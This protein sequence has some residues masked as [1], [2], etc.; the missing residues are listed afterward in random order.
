MSFDYN[1]LERK[2]A[3][4]KVYDAWQYVKSLQETLTYMAAS[5]EL[6]VK[7]Y[8]HRKKII[9]ETEKV[10]Y[11]TAME[12]G[13]A[14]FGENE[15]NKTNL[16]I[17]GY[18]IDDSIFLRKTALEFF[19][20]SRISMDVLF[21]I[22]NAALLG[23]ESYPVTD[24]QLLYDVSSK[25]KSKS[26][27]KTLLQLLNSNKQD[28][29]FKYLMAFDNHVK[30]IKTILI[31]I[32]NSFMIGEH[33][34]FVINGFYNNGVFYKDEVAI[35]KIKEINNYV[36]TTT[37]E[38][39]KEVLKQ[40]PN[41]IDNSQRVH[42]VKFKMQVDKA[43]NG[44][45]LSYIAF[46]IEVEN[47]L[48]DLPNE[49]KVLPLIIKPND[50]IYSFDLKHEKIFIRKIGSDENE[51]IG[52]AQLKNGIETNEFYRVFEVKTCDKSDYFKYIIDFQEKYKGI[53]L[54]VYAMEGQ[55][56]FVS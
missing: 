26:D 29:R 40:V 20:Y 47:G 48:G 37:E 45:G 34:E 2:L 17:A 19:H 27:F 3:E 30:H 14:S 6:L 35:D 5:Y 43:G 28:D 54:N 49:I 7:V 1:L 31:T 18:S 22:I 11:E 24:R 53:S 50:E 23:D 32:K 25:L 44:N 8:E 55:M 4:K 15:L 38:I 13:S 12:K 42:E 16:D 36:L 56:I 41:C 21:Q 52:C 9:S 51:I 46:F 33:D 39:L 10:I